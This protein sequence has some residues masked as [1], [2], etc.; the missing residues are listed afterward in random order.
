MLSFNHPRPCP[1][2][3]LLRFAPNV[4]DTGARPE[5]PRASVLKSLR[6]ASN[7]R[8]GLFTEESTGPFRLTPVALEK[9]I[10]SKPSMAPGRLTT[11][12]RF[13]T[14]ASSPYPPGRSSTSLRISR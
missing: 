2:I 7:P 10:A 11:P 14:I 12:G 1:Y 9:T 5:W 8:L 13:V 6:E 3:R 4:L